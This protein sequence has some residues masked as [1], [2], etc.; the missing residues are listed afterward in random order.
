LI[1]YSGDLLPVVDGLTSLAVLPAVIGSWFN[2]PILD[3]IF[4]L[5]IGIAIVFITRDAIVAMW[6][7]LMDAVDP[8]FLDHAESAIRKNSAVRG[9]N[10]LR[11]RWVGH[12]MRLES[13]I[14]VDSK[15]EFSQITTIR[16]QIDEKINS[17]AALFI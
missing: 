1:F 5:I 8:H 2:A 4:G 12:S 16:K 17:R 13:C 3:P 15:L 9:I 7:R 10:Y 11:L 6:Y 14:L